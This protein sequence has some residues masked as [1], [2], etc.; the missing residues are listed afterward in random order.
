MAGHQRVLGQPLRRKEDMRL[1]TGAGCFV[2][3]VHFHGLLYLGVV[4]SP[5]AHARILRIDKSAALA[6]PGV[7]EVIGPGDYAELEGPMPELLEP[8]TLVNPYCDLH[9]TNPHH[10]LPRGK[11]THQGEAIAMV[12]AE[13]RQ[14]AALGADAVDVDYEPLAAVLCP[15]RAMAADS[16]R[17]HDDNPNI[18]GHLKV[19]VGDI[20]AAFRDADVVIEERLY[21]QRLASMSIEGRGIVASW[22]GMRGEMTVWATNQ[23]PYRLRDTIARMLGLPYDQVR[24]ISRDVGG[25]FGGK[26]LCPEDLV[27]AA[28]SRRRARPVK[29]IETRSENF[30]GAHARDQIHDV[31]VAA[32]MDGT[33][34]GIDVKLIKDVGAYNHYEMVQTTNTVNHM[35]SHFK[36]PAF[37][38]EG[39]CVVTNKVQSRPT[40]GAGRPEASFVMDRIL[41]FVAAET[42]LDPLHVRMQNIIPAA[43]M[44]YSNGLTY[45]D[46]VPITYDG[47]DYPH[48]LRV[49][50]ERFDYKGWRKQQ[51]EARSRGRMIGIGMSSSLEAG[52]VG[53][54]EGARVSIDDTGRVNVFLGVNCH[55][56]SHETTFAQVCAEY[57]GVPYERVRVAGG[58]TALLRIGYG[59]GAS[60]VGVNVGNAV[61]LASLALRDKLR[62]FA[63][64]VLKADE[65]DILLDAEHASVVSDPARRRSFSELARAASA[66]KGM[67]A[68]DGP[69]LGATEFYYPDTVTWSSCVH[70]V[71]VEVDPETGI[72][73]VLKYVMSHDCG[74]PMNP[75][76]VDGQLQGGAVQGIGAA[77]GEE[78]VYDDAGQLLTGSFMDYPMPRAADV[79]PFEVEHLVYPTDRNPLGV[80]AAGEGGPISPPAALAG[81][82]E[83]AIGC[84]R[85][86]TRMPLTPR[87]VFELLR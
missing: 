84:R 76:V 37:R 80:R 67:S 87:R 17:V 55:G 58:D 31:R 4:R 57:L 6:V 61:M 56:Q 79:P 46:G 53:P 15:E 39:W 73:G 3:D 77:L 69:G 18:I 72:V 1:L 2:D 86:V 48:M 28:V 66:S 26:G 52:G 8:G 22:D 62:R 83:D 85:R 38:A 60:R 44:P 74:V 36:V 14:A 49:A 64:H 71:A 33:L 23:Q 12:V 70:M 10:V 41:D 45:R 35:L 59:T 42:R 9:R 54:C 32:R 63:A 68:L 75:T 34:L 43:E 21:V 27:A 81:A 50:A 7:L 29:W 51:A 19:T 20:D 47:G 78:L 11:T 30:V 65:K 24:V 25:A 40:R 16:P 5:H 82:V 13:T